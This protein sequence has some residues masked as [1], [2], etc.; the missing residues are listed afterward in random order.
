MVA[1]VEQLDEITLKEFIIENKKKNL[2]LIALEEVDDLELGVNTIVGERGS[3]LS[4]GQNQRIILARLLYNNPEILILD[5]FTNSLDPESEN[6]VIEKL[7]LL[8]NDKKKNFFII[9]HKI[10]PLK[11]CDEI[12]VVE[13]G[14][15]LKIYKFE[16]FYEKFN[17]LY[18]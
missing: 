18:D 16:E 8:K 13:N 5:E 14:K 4:G 7:N 12:I 9:S 17:F 1:E 2:N 11:L 10:K 6:H 3:F 15:I